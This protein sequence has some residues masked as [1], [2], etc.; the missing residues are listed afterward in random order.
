MEHGMI[1]NTAKPV[2]RIAVVRLTAVENAV[3]ITASGRFNRLADLVRFVEAVVEQ[4]QPSPTSFGHL[5]IDDPSGREPV[6]ER[7]ARQFRQRCLVWL[8]GPQFV[9]RRGGEQRSE[10]RAVG[11]R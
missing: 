7:Q 5:L 4:K 2:P 10:D 1:S 3:P 11:G 8:A 9:E 6:L